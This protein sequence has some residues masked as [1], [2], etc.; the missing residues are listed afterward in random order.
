MRLRLAC[1]DASVDR[2][3]LHPQTRGGP[4]LCPVPEA[5]PTAAAIPTLPD[6]R[7]QLV[8]PR[9]SGIP[10]EPGGGPGAMPPTGSALKLLL[11]EVSC[12]PALRPGQARSWAFGILSL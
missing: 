10:V 6:P 4:V 11:L 9:H 12:C 7:P 1:P 5:V 8:T 2:V 3:S